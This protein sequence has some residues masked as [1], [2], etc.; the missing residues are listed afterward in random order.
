MDLSIF[1]SPG[2]TC[3]EDKRDLSSPGRAEVRKAELQIFCSQGS[4]EV[5]KRNFTFLKVLTEMKCGSGLTRTWKS[6]QNKCGRRTRSF[7]V[8]TERMHGKRNFRSLAVKAEQNLTKNW[9]SRSVERFSCHIIGN[10]AKWKCGS[11]ISDLWQPYQV[12]S[13][14]AELYIFDRSL[15]Y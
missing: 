11:R 1:G 14:E 6:W 3:V 4:A 13:V 9:Q 7:E 5:W 12:R 8:L 10:Q 2:R 15:S